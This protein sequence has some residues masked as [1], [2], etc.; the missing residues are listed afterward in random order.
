MQKNKQYFKLYRK[1]ITIFHTNKNIYIKK[2]AKY[3][4][5][6]TANNIA[7][8][9]IKNNRQKNIIQSTLKK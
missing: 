6:K 4:H 2:H 5:A 1:Y 3:Q 7:I 8:H 9:I